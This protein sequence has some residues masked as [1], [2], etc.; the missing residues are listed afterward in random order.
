MKKG[1]SRN[2]LKIGRPG[3]TA[4]RG[5]ETKKETRNTMG[6]VNLEQSAGSPAK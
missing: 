2:S 5:E 6:V 1:K 4:G 3:V